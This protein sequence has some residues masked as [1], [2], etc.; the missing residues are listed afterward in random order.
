MFYETTED[1]SERMGAKRR[2]TTRHVPPSQFATEL[3]R[4]EKQ[5]S[6][7][8]PLVTSLLV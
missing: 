7:L 1:A 3:L 5:I 4:P 6:V 8:S 2:K